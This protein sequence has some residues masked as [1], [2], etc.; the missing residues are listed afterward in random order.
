MRGLVL[1]AVF[2]A[3]G[4]L[5]TGVSAQ[6]AI[7]TVGPKELEA[8]VKSG[9]GKILVVNLWATWCAPCIAEI[10]DLIKVTRDLADKN[11]QL[12]GVAVDEPRQ[13]T[14]KIASMRSK[15]FPEFATFA[16]TEGEL[17]DLISVVDPAW[18]EVVPTTYII[19][20]DGKVKSRIQG[21]KSFEEFR[22]II[23]SAA[24]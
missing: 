7:Q 18:N 16:R 4:F 10:P 22:A 24:N 20:R 3:F 23:Q 15:Y 11:V 2:V 8:A 13:G 19:G 17:D 14:T 9:A 21:K 1:A 12:I 6:Q 5:T